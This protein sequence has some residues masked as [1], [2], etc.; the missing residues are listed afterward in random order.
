MAKLDPRAEAQA[1]LDHLTSAG[2]RAK[3]MDGGRCVLASMRLQPVPFETPT[4]S[5]RIDQVI[6]STVG[7]F[8]IKCLR[9]HALFQLPLIRI[10]DCRDTLALEARI[11]LAWKR[12]VT[13][14]AE[15][16]AWLD[17]LGVPAESL[18]DGASLAFAIEGERR[19][20]RVRVLE[21]RRVALPGRGPLSGVRLQRAED[22]TL[23]L[24]PGIRSSVELEIAVSSRLDELLRL[25]R[26]LADEQRR[27]PTDDGS[28]RSR[29]AP[30]SRPSRILLVGPRLAREQGCIDS[31]HLRGYVVD[32]AQTEPEAIAVFDRCSPE[33]VL[34]DVDMGRND[35]TSLVLELRRVAGIEEIPVVL[36]DDVRRDTVREAARRVGAA[37][38]LVHPVE[39]PRIAGQL[40]HLISEPR[41][42]RYTRYGRRLPVEL[43]GSPDPCMTTSLGRGGMFVATDHALAEKTLHRCRI[44]LPEID[45]A[46]SCETEVLYRRSGLGRSRAGYGVRFHS[47]AD[48]GE[49]L[50]IE[51][52]RTIDHSAASARAV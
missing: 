51:Y 26:R 52:L 34:A 21:P 7:R 32:T 14:L 20:T 4:G 35:G 11:R 47:F 9:P 49:N 46:V 17:G 31:L 5:L 13:G 29:E 23:L 39:V 37:G 38:Y 27:A 40:A 50:L 24:D 8:R 18:D 10:H 30:S 1:A 6:F 41:R 25:D 48:A 2:V 12:H 42:R 15:A 16:Q 22:R 33:L 44:V 45:S 43:D 36:V 28:A 3:L 19:R